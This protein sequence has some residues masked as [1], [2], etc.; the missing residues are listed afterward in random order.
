LFSKDID[1]VFVIYL[2]PS[3]FGEEEEWHKV[4]PPLAF[5]L[6]GTG[7]SLKL[8]LAQRHSAMVYMDMAALQAPDARRL[9]ALFSLRKELDICR[10]SMA[11]CTEPTDVR[12]MI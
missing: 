8:L 4:T 3:Y 11:R 7:R 10:R 12:T 2:Y 5:L 6:L 1:A 9:I